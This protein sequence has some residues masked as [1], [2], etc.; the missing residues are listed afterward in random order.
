MMISKDGSSRPV[1]RAIVAALALT[2]LALV[3]CQHQ[4]KPGSKDRAEGWRVL[5]RVGNVRMARDDSQST[6]PIRPGETIADGGM[7]AVDQG[8]L[9]I[10]AR[11]GVQLTAG[12]N[13]SVRLADDG[14]GSSLILDRGWLRVRLATPVDQVARIR[15]A[16]FDINAST[17]TLTL[18]AGPDRSDLSI[19]DGSATLATIDGRHQ[20]T[21]VAGAAARIDRRIDSALRIRPASGLA[22]K[23]IVPFPAKA[24]I[25]KDDPAP[26]TK[27]GPD[28]DST[29][30]GPS[31]ASISSD[32]IAIRPAS[33]LK[34]PEKS[35]RN[36]PRRIEN[37]DRPP[38]PASSITE[39]PSGSST[40]RQWEKNVTAPRAL[41]AVASKQ[42]ADPIVRRDIPSDPKQR[43]F[44]R[45]TEGLLDGLR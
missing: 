12:E 37:A 13:T 43:Q 21:L 6:T 31:A 23:E 27:A 3:G 44:D 34:S 41:P 19:E 45:L 14:P 17:A 8:A 29:I 2:M 9:L 26:S 5:E 38:L 10:L 1:G 33:R 39:A 30:G 32:P 7:I 11:Q 36:A 28:V 4:S 20:T 35:P 42:P 25:R 24:Q 15:S 16:A 22:F 40:Y 18:R